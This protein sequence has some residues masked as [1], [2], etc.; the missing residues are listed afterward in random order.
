MWSRLA[1]IAFGLAVLPAPAAAQTASS[2]DGEPAQ[3]SSQPPTLGLNRSVPSL[4]QGRPA[5][6]AR[7][8]RLPD[9]SP[10]VQ[11]PTPSLIRPLPS[12]SIVAPSPPPSSSRQQVRPLVSPPPALNRQFRDFCRGQAAGCTR[13][14]GGSSHRMLIE[15]QQQ[16]IRDRRLDQERIRQQRTDPSRR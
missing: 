10:G 12:P 14:W 1:I 3:S 9:P 15:Q 8:P 2:A 6:S 5:I 4:V 16:R 13:D 7:V 11:R